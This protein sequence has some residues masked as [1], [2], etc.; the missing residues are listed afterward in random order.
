MFSLPSNPYYLIVWFLSGFFAA[1]YAKRSGKNPIIWFFIGF[2]LGAIGIFAF[3]FFGK[4]QKNKTTSSSQTPQIPQLNLYKGA[5][6]YALDGQ[7]EGPVSDYFIKEQFE[8]NALSTDTLV[9]HESMS[10]W[11]QLKDLLK[12]DL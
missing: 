1:V 12:T 6:Y 4:K 8:K 2:F 10:D 7:I 11:A 3:M 9:W 5:W